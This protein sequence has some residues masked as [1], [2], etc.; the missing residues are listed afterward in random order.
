M[1][2]D[3][4]YEVIFKSADNAEIKLCDESHPIF[5]A[6]FP[7]KP[8]FPGFIHFEIV[9]KLFSL[10]ITTIKKAKFINLVSPNEI[11]V[12]ERKLNTF[13]VFSGEKE[14]ANFSL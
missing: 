2:Y 9:S 7:T 3:G 10:D 11:L 13:K 14:V 5:K 12:Y 8:V 6:H 1:N 4:L